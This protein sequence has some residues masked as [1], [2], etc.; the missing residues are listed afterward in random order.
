MCKAN[1]QDGNMQLLCLLSEEKISFLIVNDKISDEL[2]V[3]LTGLQISFF[4]FILYRV[5]SVI[6]SSK[7]SFMKKIIYHPVHLGE[8]ATTVLLAIAFVSLIM[9][10]SYCF[11]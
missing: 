3:V 6:D 11:V 4:F 2:C 8:T 1:E 7:I 5:E 10:L 9:V